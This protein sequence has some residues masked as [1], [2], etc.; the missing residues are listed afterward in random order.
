MNGDAVQ[1]VIHL[2]LWDMLLL[3]VPIAAVIAIG[4]VLRLGQWRQV[5]WAT[6]RATVQLVAVGLVIGW[7]FERDTWYWIIG[8]LC[9][10]TLIA[11]FTAGG[12]LGRSLSRTSIVFSVVMG[13]ST[14]VVLIY[15]TQ[16]VVDL[17]RWDPRYI[18]P[19]GG[20]LLGN[21]MTAATL[22]IERMT[23]D[24]RQGASDVEVYLA[25]GASPWQAIQPA[26]RR[27]IAA[28][29]MPTLNA[30]LIMGVVKLPGMMTG[31][32]LGGTEPFQAALYQL[33]ILVGLLATEML[34]AIASAAFCYRR[35]FTRAWQLDR[36][37]L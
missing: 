8:L 13:L 6:V 25:L 31:Q 7:V 33:L 19:L 36:R 16:A 9:V 12:R 3:A 35:F 14:A 37:A 29:L 34:T 23:S 30:M 17:D 24:L 18:I 15:L 21:A 11:G 20:M 22:A 32:M 5:T 28:A 27:S 2:G 1:P 4:L 10:M 26:L